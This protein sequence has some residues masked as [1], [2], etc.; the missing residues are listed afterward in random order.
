[1][2]A[3]E[4]APIAAVQLHTTYCTHNPLVARLREF[5]AAWSRGRG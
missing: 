4:A 1:M 3:C 2:S 5:E